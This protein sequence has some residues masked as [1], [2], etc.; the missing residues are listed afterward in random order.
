MQTPEDVKCGVA[1]GRGPQPRPGTVA[2]TLVSSTRY[3]RLF[4][5]R[6][7]GRAARDPAIVDCLEKNP[8]LVQTIL[9]STSSGWSAGQEGSDDRAVVASAPLQGPQMF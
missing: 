4:S 3:R 7:L 1:E 5:K 8:W 9:S 2:V 6:V